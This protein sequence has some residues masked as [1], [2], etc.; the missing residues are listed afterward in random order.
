MGAIESAVDRFRRPEYTGE[1]RCNACTVV[2]VAIALLLGVGT[3]LVLSWIGYAAVGYPAAVGLFVVCCV[4]I[5]LRGYLVPGTPTLTKRYF[6]PWLLAVFG[7]DPGVPAA[8]QEAPGGE[9]LDIEASLLE[10]GALEPR[11]DGTDLRLVPALS[12][13]WREEIERVR[14]GEV[15]RERLAGIL[16]VDADDLT[17]QD[18]RESFVAF[19]RGANVGTWESRAAYV[20]DVAAAPVLER[21]VEDWPALSAPDRGRLLNGLRIFLEACPECD[22]PLSFGARTVESCCSTRDV[23]ALTCEDCEARLFEADAA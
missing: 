5:A 18:F 13:E 16:G 1:N 9:D 21:R 23:A 15:D 19:H 8:T 10:A 7:K 14:D 2:N 17:F 22:G 6:P 12:E 20:A 3:A 4:P 11:P